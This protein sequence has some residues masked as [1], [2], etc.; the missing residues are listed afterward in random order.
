MSR[1][2][3]LAAASI[4][5]S[6]GLFGAG[7]TGSFFSGGMGP[8]PMGDDDDDM[9]PAPDAGVVNPPPAGNAKPLF[10]ST[11]APIMAASCASAGCHG[12]TGTSP[13]KFL[14]ADMASYYDVLTS[15]DDRV[16]GYFDKAVAP[17]LTKM[18]P[19]PHYA[20]Y[21]QAEITAISEWLDA[22]VTAR[23]GG[24]PPPPTGT[25]PGELS[26]QL[27]AEWSGCMDLSTWNANNVAVEWAGLGSSEGP[28]IR[29]H[30]NGQASMIATDDSPYMF[31]VLT[32]SK[33]FMLT[34]FTPNVSD[35]AN[36]KMEINYDEFVRVATNVYPFLEHPQFDTDSEAMAA[37]E[38][39][40][41]ATMARKA[42]GTCD[43]PRLLP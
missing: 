21:T 8:D 40:Y 22:E 10:D 29:C 25:T 2:L 4:G 11:V 17:I 27:M 16:V 14:P 7:C 24:T 12:G 36:G 20:T 13:L 28:C 3:L 23:N 18:V 9:P 19:G 42:A 26:K 35:L 15:Y 1:K 34:Y 41:D 39:F 38:A 31:E 5:L 6:I 32:T 33:Y 30:V 37:L 43:P